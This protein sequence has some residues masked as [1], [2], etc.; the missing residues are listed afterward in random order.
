[1][2]E[3]DL[4]ESLGVTRSGVRLAIDGLAAEGLVEPIPNRGARV[5]AVSTAEA[6]RITPVRH[7]R[8]RGA[9]ARRSPG[10]GPSGG[11]G[12]MRA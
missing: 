1:M 2:V 4:V 9:A 6:V 12:T 5:R 10:S 8:A 11:P 7:P 3:A